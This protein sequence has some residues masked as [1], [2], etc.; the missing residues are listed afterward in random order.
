[1]RFGFIGTGLMAQ[2]HIRNLLL[3][4]EAE[5]V[6]LADPIPSSLE[7]ARS[8]LGARGNSVRTYSDTAS[9]LK[10]SKLD[11][12]VVASPNYTH[13]DLLSPLF[14]TDLHILCEKPLATTLPDAQWILERANSHRGI[15]WVGMEYRFMPPVAQFIRET[16]AGRVG[17]LQRIAMTEHRFPFLPKVGDWNRFNRNT[18]GTMVEKCCHFFDLMRLIS[19]GEPTQVYCSGAMDVN[20][21]EERYDGQRPDIIDNAFAVVDF[22]NGIRAML[23]LCMFAEGSEQQEELAVIGDVAKLT[24]SIPSAMIE[25]SPRVPLGTAKRIERTHVRVDQAVLD[26]GHHHGATFHQW[27]A[28]FEAAA[29]RGPVLVTAR[30]GMLAV[31]MGLAAEISAAEKRAVK[32]SELITTH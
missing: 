16:A 19:G 2:E 26:A 25:Y 1:M 27:R 9:M 29:G 6:A 30:D 13:A 23:D 32:M 28:F 4:E 7:W 31:A 14:D 8:T 17:K 11:A 22:D 20:H 18:G 5:I 10:S 12:V 3:F 24:V 15:F 21:R